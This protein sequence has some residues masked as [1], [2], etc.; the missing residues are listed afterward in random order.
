LG[1]KRVE[2]MIEGRIEGGVED[3]GRE[4]YRVRITDY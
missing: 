3:G 4:E 2:L 1:E